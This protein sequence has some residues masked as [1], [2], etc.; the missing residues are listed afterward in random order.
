MASRSR[1]MLALLPACAMTGTNAPAFPES[2]ICAINARVG[3]FCPSQA[4]QERPPLAAPCHR[5][6]R[7]AAAFPARITSPDMPSIAP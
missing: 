2:S 5:N 1:R 4:A 7:L 6:C 3:S